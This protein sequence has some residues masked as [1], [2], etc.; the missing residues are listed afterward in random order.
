[1]SRILYDSDKKRI[2][3]DGDEQYL[4][5]G[6]DIDPI[7]PLFLKFQAGMYTLQEAYDKYVL[8]KHRGYL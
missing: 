1:M 5:C 6:K 2:S 3:L 4:D 7:I 8:Y